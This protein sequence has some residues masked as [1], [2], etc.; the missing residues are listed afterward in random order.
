[1]DDKLSLKEIQNIETHLFC[2]SNWQKVELTSSWAKMFPDEAGVYILFHKSKPVYVGETGKISRRMKNMLDSR[3]HTVR[4][5]VGQEQYSKI[6]GYQ[7]AS[8]SKKFPEHIEILVE[9]FICEFSIC[10]KVV[11]FGRKEI[12]EYILKNYNPRYNHKKKRK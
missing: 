3:Q 6:D 12:E 5:S 10:A 7:K 4:R 8:S 1:M 11:K 9:K 2:R